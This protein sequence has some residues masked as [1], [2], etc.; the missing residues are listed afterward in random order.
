MSF[1]THIQ[2][3]IIQPNYEHEIKDFL[4]DRHAWRKNG[5]YL[6][7]ISKILLGASTMT[8]FAAGV[9]SNQTLSFVG[10]CLS[11]AS[12]VCFQFSNYSRNNSN[13]STKEL[14]Q[15]LEILNI[16]TLPEEKDLD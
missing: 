14:N 15:T 1:S 3:D 4:D 2:N 5:I 6:E 13:R 11:T 16:Q 7:T 8:S 9:Y 12:L 10:G